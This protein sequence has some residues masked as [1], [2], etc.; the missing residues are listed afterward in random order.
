MQLEARLRLELANKSPDLMKRSKTIETTTRLVS[1][2]P[3]PDISLL[4]GPGGARTPAL[5]ANSLVADVAQ[6]VIPTT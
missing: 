4:P 2:G 6:K 3:M 5:T 1:R